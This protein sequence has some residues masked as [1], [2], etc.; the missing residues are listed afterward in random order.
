M[1]LNQ[2]RDDDNMTRTPQPL[3]RLLSREDSDVFA[4]LGAGPQDP[5]PGGVIRVTNEKVILR[6]K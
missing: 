5:T 3:R 1:Y 6:F 2:Q 4:R